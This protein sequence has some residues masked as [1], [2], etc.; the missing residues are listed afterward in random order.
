M[1]VDDPMNTPAM[2]QYMDIKYKYPDSILFFRM[3]DFY[4]MFQEDAIIA[5]SILDIALTKRQ[6]QIPMCGIPYHAS[7]S[8]TSRL[9]TAGKRVVICEQI[10]SNDPNTKLL[11][12]EVVRVLSPGTI[13]EENLIKGYENNFLSLIFFMKNKISLAFI[14][15]STSEFYFA[16]YDKVDKI[17]IQSLM[18]KFLPSELLLFK[19]HAISME[20][21]E[22]ELNLTL[23]LLDSTSIPL[24]KNSNPDDLKN[25]FNLF[26]RNSLKDNSI[27]L[28]NPSILSNTEYME[29]DSNT[30]KN[31]ELIF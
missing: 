26:L 8:Y 20:N 7:E 25:I 18:N 12:R 24:P 29:L 19:E 16:E 9:L 15:I 14:D 4:E 13:V 10:K 17:N 11:Q 2:K 31:L 27:Q 21:L 6:N 3:G 23:T 30:I 5:S 22:L 1:S 28:S